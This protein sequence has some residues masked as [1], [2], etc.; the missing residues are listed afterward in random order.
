MDNILDMFG[1]PI[2]IGDTVLIYLP[3]IPTW[4][5]TYCVVVGY[6]VHTYFGIK[7]DLVKSLENDSITHEA[8]PSDWLD[9]SYL[10][11]IPKNI[12]TREGRLFF[13]NMI[14]APKN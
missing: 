4:H 6:K 7:Y 5:K 1:T 11:L 2:E 14:S 12:T 9:R 3:T 10:V 13:A 8:G